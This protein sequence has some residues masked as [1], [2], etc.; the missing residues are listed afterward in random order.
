MAFLYGLERGVFW[1][2]VS[3]WNT[4]EN[5]HKSGNLIEPVHQAQVLLCLIG[6]LK[7]EGTIDDLRHGVGDRCLVREEVHDIDRSL[8]IRSIIQPFE[9][10]AERGVVE[11]ST[12]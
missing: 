8:D 3:R 7:V 11:Q 6:E 9:H 1:I 12:I 2:G 5:L 10:S 4:I